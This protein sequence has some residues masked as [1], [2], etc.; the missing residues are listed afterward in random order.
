MLAETAELV[1]SGE[2]TDDDMILDRDMPGDGA[3]I[4]KNDVIADRAIVSD[5]RVGEEISVM[6]DAGLGAWKSA[7]VHCAKFAER[8]VVSD[9][10][11][12]RL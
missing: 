9:F 10:Q 4:R 3:V 12:G 6:A 2:A 5:V 11:I 8:V 7:S 1:D